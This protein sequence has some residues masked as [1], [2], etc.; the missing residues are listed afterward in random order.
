MRLT[1]VH[2]DQPLRA[3]TEL[4]LPEGPAT[5][6]ARVLRLG[7]GDACVLFNGDGHDYPARIV[8]L[9]KRELRVAIDAAM[10]VERESPLRLVL[11]QGIARGEKMD[12]ILQKATE[13]GVAEVRPLWSQ[14]SEVKLDE[15]RAEKRLAHW[16]S[17][18]ASAC[19]QSGR[20][21][22]PEVA[23][24]LSLSA[25]LAALPAGGLRLILD[26]EGEL[27][28]STLSVD[29][30]AAVHLAIGPEGGWS[31]LDREQL[32]AAG[33]LGLR[34][35]PRILRTETAGLA[36]IAALQARFGDLA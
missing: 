27:A 2:V 25:A 24:P 32:R 14:R 5:H 6:L 15:A 30:D 16:R 17:V 28:F 31:P 26:P 33:F 13:L 21:R 8:A 23:A 35:G 4:A 36:A 22:V 10:P 18:V 20:A 12:L 11:L 29:A 3:G 9:G 7:V 1:R 34:L 19:E